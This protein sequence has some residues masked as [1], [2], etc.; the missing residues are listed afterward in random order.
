MAT[1][2]ADPWTR[3]ADDT[4]NTDVPDSCDIAAS[5][6]SPNSCALPN[7]RDNPLASSNTSEPHG[8]NRGVN[9]RATSIS[10]ARGTDGAY[11]A[12]NMATPH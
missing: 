2:D 4:D 6:C 9:A 5:R 12:A 11:R 8:S 1:D 3:A 7:K 10:A